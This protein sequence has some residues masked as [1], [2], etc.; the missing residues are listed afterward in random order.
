MKI[1]ITGTPGTGKTEVAPLVAKK[2][3]WKYVDLNELAKDKDLFTGYDS[4]RKCDI[5][6]I[7][8]LNSEMK[9][10]K[11][12]VIFQSH[13]AHEISCDLIIVLRTSIGELRR[14]LAKRNWPKDKVDENIEAEIMDVCKEESLSKGKPVF[15]VDT[16][17]REA[18]E[19]ATETADIITREMILLKKS[20][21]LPESMVRYFKKP[22]GKVFTSVEDVPITERFDNYK[23]LIIAVGDATSYNMVESGIEPDIIIVDQKERRAPFTRKIRF[24]DK[25]YKVLNA[26][27]EISA[28]LWN[29]IKKAVA[30]G[31]KIKI[32][33]I[34][35]EDLAVLPCVIMAPTESRIF[36]GQPEEGVVIITVTTEKKADAVKLLK[37]MIAEQ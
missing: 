35:E 30:S 16:T 20:L 36:Y 10:I 33:V 17:D 23:G 19:T 2:I 8:K 7:K 27:G 37:K 32:S 4:K 3:G 13:Y 18:E 21:K 9:K 5:V 12:D 26:P 24:R 6:D 31:E 29:T 14:R 25:E 28:G 1:C 15:E 22:Y 11:G 34:G